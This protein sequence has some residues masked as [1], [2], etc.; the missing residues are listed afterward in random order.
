[1]DE[2]IHN[3]RHDVRLGYAQISTAQTQKKQAAGARFR[4]Q[5]DADA[6]MH[7]EWHRTHSKE[8]GG[9]QEQDE[10]ADMQTS[11]NVKLKAHGRN[12]LPLHLPQQV[13]ILDDL[14]GREVS[15]SV[16]RRCPLTT[17]DRARSDPELS[18]TLSQYSSLSL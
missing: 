10:S 3:H 11:D 8:G 7:R 12:N 9:C 16:T 5:D 6:K 17:R 18:F 13:S 15:M 1:M 14:V 4:K 2:Q